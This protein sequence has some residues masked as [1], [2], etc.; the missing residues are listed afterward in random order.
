MA[1]SIPSSLKTAVDHSNT[2]AC[3][4]NMSTSAT[5]QGNEASQEIKKIVEDLPLD[6]ATWMLRLL[7]RHDIIRDVSESCKP[8][9]H[10][11]LAEEIKD[12]GLLLPRVRDMVEDTRKGERGF[13]G[14]AGPERGDESCYPKF[15][16]PQGGLMQ[17]GV[18][19]TS[20]CALDCVYTSLY[21]LKINSRNLLLYR[22][23]YYE[24]II[25][26]EK[27]DDVAYTVV[28]ANEF[29]WDNLSDEQKGEIEGWYDK[30]S[31]RLGISLTA[32]NDPGFIMK[33]VLNDG[34]DPYSVEEQTDY[35]CPRGHGFH[36]KPTRTLLVDT[37]SM[38]DPPGYPGMMPRNLA[39]ALNGWLSH[40]PVDNSGGDSDGDSDD[41]SDGLPKCPECKGLPT[42]HVCR[43][44]DDPPLVVFV[45]YS[46]WPFEPPSTPR[47]VAITYWS[48]KN[49]PQ[50]ASYRW[51]FTIAGGDKT[52]ERPQ[53]INHYRLYHSITGTTSQILEYDPVETQECQNP[54][55]R[56][57][58]GDANPDD[59]L[60]EG[61]KK[62]PRVVAM[63]LLPATAEGMSYSDWLY[64]K[65][66]PEQEKQGDGTA[67]AE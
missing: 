60:P 15:G 59:R 65:H 52:G 45:R 56:V 4:A 14:Y 5:E 9:I 48:R 32:L 38:T 55:R 39:D 49:G 18:S 35:Y 8:H 24:D 29:D 44:V 61:W 54:L 33:R 63:E 30:T 12:Q 37:G 3:T 17:C 53:E 26:S 51:L 46:E 16:L 11:L 25:E 50:R 66:G 47:N 67:T 10:L 27:D 20:S 64:G 40:G 58:C 23:E 34:L 43:L 57:Q 2:L 21:L 6:H 28:R 41:D 7:S 36:E 19:A 1:S 22:R 13:Y 31:A 62:H 42:R